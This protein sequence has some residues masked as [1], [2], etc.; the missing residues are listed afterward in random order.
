MKRSRVARFPHKPFVSRGGV[1]YETVRRWLCQKT[2]AMAIHYSETADTSQRMPDIMGKF[3]LLGS[4][5][6]T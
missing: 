3:D 6:R 4:E 2:L 1:R 5:T